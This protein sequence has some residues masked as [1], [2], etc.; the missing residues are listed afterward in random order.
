M[1]FIDFIQKEN[2]ELYN[3]MQTFLSSEFI[4]QINYYASLYHTTNCT[5]VLPEPPEDDSDMLFHECPN[6]NWRCNCNDQPCSCC[7]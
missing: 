7:N 4:G 1:E 5:G 2:Y 3:K 6:C